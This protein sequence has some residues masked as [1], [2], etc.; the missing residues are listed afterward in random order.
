M[1]WSLMFMDPKFLIP[2]DIPRI[3]I[4]LDMT[5]HLFPAVFLWIDFLVFDVQFKRST[6]HIKIIYAFAL[7]YYGW[8]WYCYSVNGYWVYPFL[9]EFNLPVRTAFF[10]ASG[11]L[12]MCMYEVGAIVHNKIHASTEHKQHNLKN[13]KLKQ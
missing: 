2:E 12:C 5:L 6:T 4:L 11:V 7:F 13:K 8:S 10:A 9:S 3:P 1:Y